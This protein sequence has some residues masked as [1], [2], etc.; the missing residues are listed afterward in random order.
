METAPT[1]SS[2]SLVE[3]VA[4]ICFPKWSHAARGRPYAVPTLDDAALAQVIA[5]GRPQAGMTS[6]GK[7]MAA[8]FRRATWITS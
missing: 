4:A 6:F 1:T 3:K 2:M 7:H 5:Y 8:S